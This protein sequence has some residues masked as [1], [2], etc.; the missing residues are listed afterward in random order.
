[1]DITKRTVREHAVSLKNGEYSAKELCLSYLEK[2]E[3]LDRG[4]GAY[5]LVD[6]ESAL[7]AADEADLRLKGKSAPLLCGIPYGAK[8]NICTKGMTTTAGSRMLEDFVPPYDATAIERLKAEGSVLLGKT[9][10]DEFA[11]GSATDNSAYKITKN[12]VDQTRIPGG[13]SGGSA[14]AVAAGLAPFALGS[15]T[16]GSVRQPAA[17][18]GV[19][20]LSP[21]YGR[22]SRYGLIAFAS[23]LDRIG[24]V[25]KNCSDCSAVFGAISGR[26]KRDATTVDGAAAPILPLKELKVGIIRDH[27]DLC[28]SGVEK[29]AMSAVE[30]LTNAGAECSFVA[31]PALKYGAECYYIISSAEASSN[32]ARYDGVRFGR[33]SDHAPEGLSDFYCKN[34]S[35]GLGDEVKRRIMFGT[36]TLSEGFTEDTYKKALGVRALIKKEYER[37]FSEYHILISPTVVSPARL[38]SEKEGDPAAVYAE[39][40]FTV[41]QSLAGL[42]ALSVPMG[43]DEKGL[44][45]AVQLTGRAFSEE[46]LL[47]VGDFL[48]KSVKREE[49]I[50]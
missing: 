9:N 29:A 12:P 27:I 45:L 26:D 32:L 42:P 31:T 24:I 44:P 8:D 19:V 23:S 17:L 43:C 28:R 46:L 1:M 16:G 4:L 35:E 36:F 20:G 14:A 7:K 34:R 41:S 22:I 38:I 15:D 33:R 48:E 2:I 47:H 6:R 30:K 40:L 13:S 39:D 25:S 18:C 5:L 49:G 21:T 50:K 37:L 10:M 3:S 11:M